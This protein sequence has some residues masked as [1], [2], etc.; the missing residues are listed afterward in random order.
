MSASNEWFEYHLTPAGW[1][2]GSEKIDFAGLKPK[3]A[4]IDRVLTV[5]YHEFM[6]SSFSKMKKWREEVWRSDDEAKVR[7]LVA[8]HG[9][10]PEGYQGYSSCE[11]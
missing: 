7:E 8:T 10:A 4:P 1:V 9:K 3:P 6:S 11:R 2:A 5:R